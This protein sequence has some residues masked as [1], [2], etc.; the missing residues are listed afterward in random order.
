MRCPRCLNEDPAYFYKGVHGYYCRKCISFSRICIEDTLESVSLD[1]PGNNS[2]EYV[3]KYPLT[4]KQKTISTQCKEKIEETDILRIY[5]PFT[6][7]GFDLLINETKL[8]KFSTNLS[9]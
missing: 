8:F 4:E 2:E 9:V 3:L 5:F 6:V 7:A 1:L